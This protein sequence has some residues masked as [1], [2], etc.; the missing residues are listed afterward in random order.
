MINVFN[1]TFSYKSV[2]SDFDDQTYK[3][4]YFALDIYSDL[5]ELLND[6]I[7]DASF[8][9]GLSLNAYDRIV[10]E[11]WMPTFRKL[12]SNQ[13]IKKCSHKCTDLL[14]KWQNLLPNWVLKNILDQIILPKIIRETEEWNPTQDTVA[15]HVWV[16]KNN[17]IRVGYFSQNILL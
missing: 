8:K 3:S 7:Y 4:P 9:S 6:K 5:K 16:G 1:L 12:M 2:S 11:T 14:H 17:F 10:W 15:I 13:S